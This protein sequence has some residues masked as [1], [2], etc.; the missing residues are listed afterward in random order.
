[1]VRDASFRGMII[2]KAE[3]AK[4][5]YG[6]PASE[7]HADADGPRLSQSLATLCVQKS[8]LHAWAA[9]PQLGAHGWRYE[10]STDDGSLIHSLVLEPGSKDIQR[11]DLSDYRNKD[12]SVAQTMANKEA[13]ADWQALLDAGRTPVMAEKLDAFTYKAKALRQ[14]FEAAG[15]QFSGASE[16]VIYWT[17]QTQHGPVDCRARLD[18]VIVDDGGV[19]II[20]LKSIE[21]ASKRGI[22]AS[23]W[24]YGYDI[25]HAAYVR[26]AE[27]A[28]PEH[29]GRVRMV[30]A[31][32]ELAKPYAVAPTELSGKF[33]RMGEKRWERGRDLWAWGLKNDD[34]RGYGRGT[35]EPPGWAEQEEMGDE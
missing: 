8:P 15:V 25:Q 18:H 22:T 32:C 33:A 11:F 1:M 7:Y 3:P 6:M 23:C 10:P 35:V 9:H 12:G 28:W 20:D 31:F 17:E 14:S 34:W 4:V 29:A 5:H 26:A 30:F 2:T 13:K 24:R 27:L 21:E 19:S 16:V